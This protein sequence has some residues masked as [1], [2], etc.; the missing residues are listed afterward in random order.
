VADLRDIALNGAHDLWLI[1]IVVHSDAKGLEGTAQDSWIATYDGKLAEYCKVF[2]YLPLG[3][4]SGGLAAFAETPTD[5]DSGYWK[6]TADFLSDLF[7]KRASQSLRK[8]PCIEEMMGWVRRSEA[9]LDVI[10]AGRFGST[11]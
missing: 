6:S 2:S 4:L 8:R 1:S 11:A 10:A 3:A 9:I 5:H 7:R